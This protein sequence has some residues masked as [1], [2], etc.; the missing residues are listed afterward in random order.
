MADTQVRRLDRIGRGDV[1]ARARR[2]AARKR[3]GTVAL[4]PFAGTQLEPCIEWFDLSLE[5][6]WCKHRHAD[7]AIPRTSITVQIEKQKGWSR[8]PLGSREWFIS[9]S[10][11]EPVGNSPWLMEMTRTLVLGQ[12]RFS[13][14]L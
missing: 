14:N 8:V 6:V 13:R 1:E 2:I 9:L 12:L 10:E 4:T 5:A 3:A 7:N 11:G